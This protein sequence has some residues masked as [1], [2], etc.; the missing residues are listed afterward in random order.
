M[1]RFRN[2]IKSGN[3]PSENQYLSTFQ[4]S[5]E[6]VGIYTF[7]NENENEAWVSIAFSPSKKTKCRRPII[8]VNPGQPVKSPANHS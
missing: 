6:Q 8:H 3:P 5:L 1:P 7:K 4:K 2:Q